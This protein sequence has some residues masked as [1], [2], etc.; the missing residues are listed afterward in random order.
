MN[1]NFDCKAT[2][3]KNEEIGKLI[4]LTG[5]DFVTRYKY[6]QQCMIIKLKYIQKLKVVFCTM[7]LI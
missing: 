5:C 6:L 1:K 4:L 7:F 3:E 2:I